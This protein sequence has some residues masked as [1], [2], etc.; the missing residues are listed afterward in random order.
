MSHHAKLI[1]GDAKLVSHGRHV[2]FQM[3]DVAIPRR[4]VAK[5]LRLIGELR[6]PPDPATA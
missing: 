5:I 1:K 3:A 4:L 2:A 6:S